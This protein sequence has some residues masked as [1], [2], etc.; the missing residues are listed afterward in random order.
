MRMP[1]HVK[2]IGA[3]ES[4]QMDASLRATP[5]EHLP[6]PA[7]SSDAHEEDDLLRRA[8]RAHLAIDQNSSFLFPKFAESF[9]LCHYVLF[10]ICVEELVARERVELLDAFHVDNFVAVPAFRACRAQLTADVVRV[11]IR[12]VV[13]SARASDEERHV[14]DWLPNRGHPRLELRVVLDGRPPSWVVGRVLDEHG[15]RSGTAADDDD[16]VWQPTTRGASRSLRM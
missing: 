8:V 4:S 9:R 3:R 1:A 16:P 6:R 2:T 10:P 14:C 15:R 7:A 5:T 13:P 11:E 12:F